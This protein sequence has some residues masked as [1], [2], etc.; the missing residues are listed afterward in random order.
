MS[1]VASILAQTAFNLF[2]S[3]ISVP[4][5]TSAYNDCLFRIVRFLRLPEEALLFLLCHAEPTSAH[6]DR[7]ESA[8]VFYGSCN[9]RKE[10][11][12]ELCRKN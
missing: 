5:Q 7:F 12:L 10:I 2:F 9:S 4:E 6:N 11:G 8:L 1:K 3:L